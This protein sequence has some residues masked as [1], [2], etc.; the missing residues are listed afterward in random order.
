MTL[1]L[2]L[3]NPDTIFAARVNGSGFTYPLAEC[4]FDG[5]T[6]GAFGDLLESM[7]VLFGAS[8]GADDL[9]RQRIR[10]AA[11]SDT[12]FFGRS[13]QGAHDGEVNLQDNAYITALWDYR[14]WA[15]IFYID[16]DTSTTPATSTHYKDHDIAVGT[17]T[18]AIPPK[19]NAGMGMAGTIDSGTSKL[20][21]TLPHEANTSW[22]LSGSISSYLWA[23]PSG[24]TLDSG[25]TSDS[26]ITVNC[27]P[28]FYWVRLTVT[29]SNGETHEMRVPIF[30]RD[31]DSDDS[32]SVFN[33]ES[34]KIKKDGQ[35][36]SIR[37]REAIAESTYPDGTLVMLWEDEPSGP[38]D[39]SHMKFIGWHQTDPASI[40]AKRTGILTDTTFQC[41]DVAGRLKALPVF[42][43]SIG[44]NASPSSWDQMSSPNLDK[45]IHYLLYWHSSALE[46]ADWS[47]S[48]VGSS[49][50]FMILESGGDSL[51]SQVA[52]RAKSMVPDY[53]LGCNTL[54]QITEN[55]DPI[56]QATG[57]RTATVQTTLTEAD[58][59][60]IRYRHQ[61][62]PRVHWLRGDAFLADGV[63]L[64]PLFCIAPGDTPGQG[65]ISQQQGHQLTQSQ[66]DLN[67][68]EGHRYARLNA[69]QTHFRI[70]LAEGADKGIEP[71]DMTWVRMDIGADAMDCQGK[72]Y[73]LLLFRRRETAERDY[74]REFGQAER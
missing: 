74:G 36:L 9:G 43:Q 7:T 18:D 27:D 24:V 44:S 51:W 63:T 10:K 31:P 59:A 37:I 16:V 29:D 41:V 50:Q 34:H 60:S 66:S 53:V 30:A 64:T 40:D 49:Y 48:G 35:E 56:V 72:W 17:F 71:A 14:V 25:L 70:V 5:V 15:K 62:P 69:E 54:G 23:L 57:S 61:R 33:I 38:T 4:E 20:Q 45:F 19:S 22:A 46:L 2:F 55:V 8:A 26:Q 32:I 68:T 6:T 13:S 21:V 12:I 3:L 58:W 42:P 52:Q 65:E 73:G 11:D 39:R 1:R 28:G 47:G 67:I